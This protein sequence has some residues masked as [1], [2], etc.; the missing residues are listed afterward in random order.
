MKVTIHCILVERDEEIDLVAHAP[1]RTVP[2]ANGE[3]GM[4][5]AND[6]LVGVVSVEVQAAPGENQGENVPG[7]CDPLAIFTA[8]S[9]RKIY[10]VH[11][12]SLSPSSGESALAAAYMQTAA[13]ARAK[14]VIRS[15]PAGRLS[16]VIV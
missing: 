15:T 4:P 2:G 13:C 1:Y 7:R 6:R 3:K 14:F 9:D 10:F 11:H 5:A 16:R 8:D 12:Q